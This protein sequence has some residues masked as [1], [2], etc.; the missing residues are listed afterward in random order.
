MATKR[1]K[2]AASLCARVNFPLFTVRVLSERHVLVGGGG[3]EAK[4][5]V[6]NS[7]EIYELTASNDGT[8]CQANRVVHYETGTYLVCVDVCVCLTFPRSFFVVLQVV[9]L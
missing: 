7:I 6:S 1:S 9:G 3:G 8:T 4:T 5:G 2:N